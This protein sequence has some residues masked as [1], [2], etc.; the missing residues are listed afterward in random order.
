MRAGGRRV[1]EEGRERTT[2]VVVRKEEGEER[3]ASYFTEAMRE[4]DCP[5]QIS[6]LDW[7]RRRNCE[8]GDR[9]G[10]ASDADKRY[11]GF[12]SLEGRIRERPGKFPLRCS[13]RLV[14]NRGVVRRVV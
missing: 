5:R 13:F 14:R 6:R 10:Q 9:A 1:R 7:E 4:E 11:L 2:R 12:A 8:R 3:W